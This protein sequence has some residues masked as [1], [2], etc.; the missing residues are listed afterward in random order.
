MSVGATGS[1][2]VESISQICDGR[3]AVYLNVFLMGLE[4]R[5]YLAVFDRHPLGLT[6]GCSGLQLDGRLDKLSAGAG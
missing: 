3:L 1:S 5:Q 4:P 6:H 2:S